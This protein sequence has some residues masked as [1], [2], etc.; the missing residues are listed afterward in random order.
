MPKL[1]TRCLYAAAFILS[2][3][4]TNASFADEADEMA[5]AIEKTQKDIL[6]EQ[7]RENMAKESPEGAKAAEK[8]KSLAGSAANEQ[9]MYGL[10]SDV[11]GN[12]KGLTQEQMMQVIQQAQKDP[13]GFLKT[14]SPE[15]RKKLEDLS[16]RL[17][18]SKAESKAKKP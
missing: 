16:G 5:A 11:L 18:A 14:W 6:N 4:I 10:A 2:S 17:P 7:T 1:T 13:E 15:Q 3:V 9:E 12:M 8:I